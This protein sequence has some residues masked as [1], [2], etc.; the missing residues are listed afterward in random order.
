MR[1]AARRFAAVSLVVTAAAAAGITALYLAAQPNSSAVPA[2]TNASPAPPGA[3]TA[4]AA[5]ATAARAGAAPSPQPP[6][7]P[8]AAGARTPA[9]AA[10]GAPHA[11][12]RQGAGAQ[13]SKPLGASAAR[14]ARPGSPHIPAGHQRR[15][16]WCW[17]WAIAT[18]KTSLAKAT[19]AGI[20]LL[21]AFL[22][23]V[24]TW[25]I[26]PPT[27]PM[28]NPQSAPPPGKPPAPAASAPR[29]NG[30]AAEKSVSPFDSN[31]A[32]TVFT[33]LGGMFAV[34]FLDS[35]WATKDFNAKSYYLV[36]F[37]LF[38]LAILFFF[39]LLRA[40]GEA[41]RSRV[42]VPYRPPV[43][44]YIKLHG[45]K[46]HAGAD[47]R[48]AGAGERHAGAGEPPAVKG[49]PPAGTTEPLVPEPWPSYWLNRFWLWL[50]SWRSS[51]LVFWDTTFNVIQG[52][53]QLETVVF[54]NSIIELQTSLVRATRQICQDVHVA[55]ID[56]LRDK[57]PAI[58][59][60][61][62]RVNVST[63]ADDEQS[64]FYIAWETGSVST[65][66]PKASMAWIA[67]VSG[68]AR[69]YKALP[70]YKEALLTTDVAVQARLGD[71]HPLVGNYYQ[72]R[73]QQDYTG[74]IVLPIPWGRRGEG[75]HYRRAG[76]HV[77]FRDHRYMDRLW[78]HLDH[79]VAHQGANE[80]KENDAEAHAGKAPASNVHDAK[81]HHDGAHDAQAHD[82]HDAKAHGVHDS[83]APDGETPDGKARGGTHIPNYDDWKGLLDRHSLADGKAGQI[84][85]QNGAVRAVLLE[86]VDVLAELLRPFN[87]HVFE[88]YIRPHID[89]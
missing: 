31:F 25:Q 39:A 47:E 87:E 16:L 30:A 52:K 13:G 71:K 53:N 1:P 3:S 61:D 50:L 56:A 35:V 82:A 10:A 63:L 49:E 89:L 86:S 32:R 7:S 9:A 33:G 11:Q 24:Q 40:G 19:V 45:S 2:S 14:S 67:V 34:T 28:A 75:G 60:W 69:W 20:A 12:P 85:P 72:D 44:Q 22:T 46:R 64:L 68:T 26:P 70:D 8:A 77:S 54:Q 15:C 27:T 65:S 43:R 4:A 18:D 23:V 6:A 36:L 74:F 84:V 29:K 48:H 78:K 58:D 83:K 76:L 62:V 59:Y 80:G 21:A 17:L 66:F 41:L 42:A 73:G 38:F 51:V 55:V 37:V 5:P 79:P 57:V 81:A 88:D